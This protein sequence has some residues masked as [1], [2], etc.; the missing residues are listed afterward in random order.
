VSFIDIIA[1]KNNMREKEY[2]KL[3]HAFSKKTVKGVIGALMK[4]GYE[5]YDVMIGG[6]MLNMAR[7]QEVEIYFDNRNAIYA[8]SD[9]DEIEWK[10]FPLSLIGTYHTHNIPKALWCHV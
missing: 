2:P 4:E 5:V 9:Y 1:S 6:Q 10:S 8:A 3:P 7:R